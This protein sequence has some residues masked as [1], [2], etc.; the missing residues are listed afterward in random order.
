[1]TQ[2]LL[3]QME[4]ESNLELKRVYGRQLFE[5]LNCLGIGAARWLTSL[6]SLIST[7]TQS[8]SDQQCRIDALENL[9]KLMESCEERLEFHADTIFEILLRLLYEISAKKHLDSNEEK[10]LKM[11]GK[12]MKKM[13]NACEDEFALHCQG[14]DEVHVNEVFDSVIS[15]LYFAAKPQLQ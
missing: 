14:L 15:D 5:L 3:Y 6:L 1:M 10:M 13:K 2:K 8:I 12:L 9:A 4:T 11:I 7:Y